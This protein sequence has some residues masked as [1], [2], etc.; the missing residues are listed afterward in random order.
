[1]S[2]TVRFA[3]S[4]TGRL[5][6]GNVRAALFNALFALKAGGRFVLRYDDTDRERS[7]EEHVRAIAEDL[8]WFG[9]RRDL[10]VRQSE[11]TALYDAAAERLKAAGRLYPCYE[12]ADELERRR[13]RQLARGLPPLYDRAALKLTPEDRARLEAEGRRPHWRFRLDGRTVAWDDAVRG[14]QTV[15]TASLSDPVLIREDGTY[16]YTL[17]SVVDDIELG[18]SHVIRGEDHVTNTGAQI[19]IFE[20]LGGPVPAFGH[21]NM[22]A[23]VAGEA[24]SKR[25]GS[26]SVGSLR[27]AGYEPMAVASLA[28]LIGSSEEIHAYPDLP[29]LA[30]HLDLAH[31]S[32]ATARFDP[33]D[34]D[35]LNAR[36]VHALPFEAVAARLAALG[37]PGAEP[38]DPAAFWD[39][40][41][42][43]LTRVG[44]AADWWRIVT[45]GPMPTEEALDPGLLAAARAALPPEPW[46]ETTWGSWTKAVSEATGL[47]G[48]ALFRPLRLA[49]TGL[50]HGP[51]LKKLLPLIGW[52]RISARLP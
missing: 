21:Y 26:L 52:R 45:E 8:D 29:S 49:L 17:P 31:V 7:R 47:K 22:I 6:I 25:L 11:R 1:M 43:N 18:I 46:D 37:I 24:L 30:A 42:P 3:P 48:K 20:A 14:A 50:D 15:D 2:V 13:K 51:E 35:A 44:E 40:V 38:I 23:T 34:L 32:M 28:V 16:L 12:P 19:E 39:A 36:L 10:T 33:H 41:R 5:H 4:P 9:I 27:E